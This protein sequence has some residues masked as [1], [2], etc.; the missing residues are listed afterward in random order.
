MSPEQAAGAPVDH[1]TDVW[2]LGVV[3]YEMLAGGVPF[4]GDVA[5]AVSRPCATRARAARRAAPD[6]PPA[7]A[8]LV[9]GALA[10][11]PAERCPSA[12][13]FAREL[14]RS[15][16]G[17]ARRGRRRRAP[18]RAP[19]RPR[20][21]R[22]RPRLR[23]RAALLAAPRAARGAASRGGAGAR[24]VAASARRG[25][26]DAAAR[27][28]PVAAAGRTGPRRHGRR[29]PLRGPQP[30]RATRSTS[31]TGSPRS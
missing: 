5:A 9:A 3:L 19:R 4:P 14:R 21:D 8:R 24:C 11:A 15:G 1:R 28:Q 30:G 27:G 31:A 18:A 20:R 13:A 12:D 16:S 22:A 10:K 23:A 6:V 7:L 29:A 26:R 17:G 2:A 25:R